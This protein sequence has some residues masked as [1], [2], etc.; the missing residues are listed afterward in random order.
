MFASDASIRSLA[1]EYLIRAAMVPMPGIGKIA[2][3]RKNYLIEE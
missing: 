1:P 2:F 3:G